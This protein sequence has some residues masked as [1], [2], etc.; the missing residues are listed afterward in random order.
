MIHTIMGFSLDLDQWNG[1]NDI[2]KIE[3]FVS[4]WFSPPCHLNRYAVKEET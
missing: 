1:C 4:G 2:Q 3:E